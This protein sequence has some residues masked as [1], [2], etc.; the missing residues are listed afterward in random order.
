[1]TKKEWDVWEFKVSRWLTEPIL[2][3]GITDSIDE[4]DPRSW[5]SISCVACNKA[6]HDV[7]NECMSPWADTESGAMC[8]DCLWPL[9]DLSDYAERETK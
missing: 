8:L 1:M 5:T 2:H 4:D 9:I 3:T 6:V 7:P